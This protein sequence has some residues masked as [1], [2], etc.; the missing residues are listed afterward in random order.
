MQRVD[1]PEHARRRARTGATSSSST[2]APRAAAMPRTVR[3]ATLSTRGSENGGAK[4]VSP[5]HQS[6]AVVAPSL[7]RP[8][9]E[10][11]RLLSA[12]S[13]RALTERAE[14][15]DVG[16]FEVRNLARVAVGGRHDE[17]RGQRGRRPQPEA[18]P[19]RRPGPG[20]A[21][22]GGTSRRP[23]GG[24]RPPASQK[25]SRSESANP[26]S[27]TV[28]ANRARCSASARARPSRDQEGVGRQRAPVSTTSQSS[29]TRSS[30]SAQSARVFRGSVLRASTR[31]G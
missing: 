29:R 20:R 28:S 12:L 14:P 11:H 17:G 7:T 4:S 3:A 19:Q 31:L 25:A 8:V 18:Q 13:L 2:G 23:G 6:S 16:P 21:R 22:T 5:R 10:D 27:R 1:R 26:C 30:P 9:V 24:T 15:V